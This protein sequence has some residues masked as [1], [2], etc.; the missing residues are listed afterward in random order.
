MIHSS[1]HFTAFVSTLFAGSVLLSSAWAASCTG[2]ARAPYACS[3]VI[4]GITFNWSSHQEHASGSDNWPVT[5][6]DDNHQYTA[7]GDGKGFSQSGGKKSF[8]VSRVIGQKDVFVGADIY[9]GAA[10]GCSGLGGLGDNTSICGKSYSIL[11]YQQFLV[12]WAGPETGA[13]NYSESRFFYSRDRGQSWTQ[14]GNY[15]TGYDFFHPT[16]L[17]YGKNHAGP[18]GGY[19]YLYGIEVLD[20]GQ[21]AVHKPGRVFLA[22]QKLSDYFLPI[23]SAPSSQQHLFGPDGN[24]FH[25]EYYTGNDAAGQPQWGSRSDKIPVFQDSNGVGW[26]LSVSY[27]AGT[28][29]YILMTEH[30]QTFAGK[31]GIFEA[32]TPWGP[33]KTVAYYDAWADQTG[34]D[35]DTGDQGFFWNIAN[36]WSSGKNFSVVFTGI[37]EDDSFNKVDGGFQLTPPVTPPKKIDLVPILQLLLL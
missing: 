19:V 20:G 4:K 3:S 10:A 5:W 24:G 12:L 21:L 29:R 9:K 13:A 34:A 18:N 7:W 35:G 36:K 26:N 23:T 25:L 33:W 27:N 11:S 31:L 6:A 8:G 14:T 16:F 1:I 2:S 17:Q 28:Q 37:G 32:P 15:L 22:R 30:D